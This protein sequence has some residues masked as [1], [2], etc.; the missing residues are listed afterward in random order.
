MGGDDHEKAS[1][2]GGS[3]D[4]LRELFRREP[5]P[6]DPR[7]KEPALERLRDARDDELALFEDKLRQDAFRAGAT[8]GEIREA[9][10]GRPGHEV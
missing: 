2:H 1:G 8:E 3:E 9:Q 5:E 6:I 10:S 4:A 7:A